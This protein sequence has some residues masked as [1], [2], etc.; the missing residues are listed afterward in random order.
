MKSPYE[1]FDVNKLRA[2]EHFAVLET[3]ADF[4]QKEPSLTSVSV[5]DLLVRPQ[6]YVAIKSGFLAGFVS[7]ERPKNKDDLIWS[8]VSTLAVLPGYENNGIGTALVRNATDYVHS[9]GL[10]AF[11]LVDQD[12]KMPALPN[13]LKNGYGM[14]EIDNHLGVVN[15]W[16]P[17]NT[18]SIMPETKSSHQ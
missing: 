10:H 6:S 13:F 9:L 18:R 8:K 1:I 7:I 16:A 17:K 4:S 5:V 3:I 11:A 14:Q 15:C 12:P 2:S